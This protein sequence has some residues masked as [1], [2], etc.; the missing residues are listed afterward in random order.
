MPSRELTY[1]TRRSE[2]ARLELRTPLRDAIERL[3]AGQ[4]VL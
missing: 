1:R 2:G 4:V 3:E